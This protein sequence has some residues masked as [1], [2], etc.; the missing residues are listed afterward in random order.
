MGKKRKKK[1]VILNIFIAAAFLAGAGIFF[2]S[3]IQR[4]VESV[5]KCLA[6]Q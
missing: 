2:L 6:D 1:N 5:Q 3:N 4:Y